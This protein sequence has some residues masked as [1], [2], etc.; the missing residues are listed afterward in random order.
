LPVIIGIDPGSRITGYG[1]VEK[2]GSGIVYIGSGAIKVGAADPMPTRLVAIK[3]GLDEVLREFQPAAAAIEE[4]FVS[5][6]PKSALKLGQARGVAILAA[7]EAGLE[8]FEYSPREVKASVTGSGSAHKSQVGAMVVRLL[9]PDH[10]PACEDE[11]DA[12]AV[13]FCHALRAGAPV[14][15]DV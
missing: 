5:K 14:W 7:A 10:E 13:A 4:V 15:R 12:L 11:T 1:L 9:R 3:R 2:R 8:V 6:N